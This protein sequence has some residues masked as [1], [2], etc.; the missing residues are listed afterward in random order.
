MDMIK[1]DYEEYVRVCLQSPFKKDVKTKNSR[2]IQV[3]KNYLY[4]NEK[5]LL[6]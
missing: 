5:R 2:E 6:S 3:I 4:L 1:K